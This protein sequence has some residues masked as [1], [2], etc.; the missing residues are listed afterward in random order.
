[1]KTK[2]IWTC[3]A[4]LPL[5]A[6]V[7]TGDTSMPEQGRPAVG[8]EYD[9]SS[10]E[11]ARAGQAEGGIMALGYE[12]IRSEGLTSWYFNRSTGACARITTSDGRYS[13]VTMLPAEDC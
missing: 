13:D 11:G 7:E 4:A 10:F 6:C 12:R 3:A 2:L 9:L 1:M 5:A 8:S